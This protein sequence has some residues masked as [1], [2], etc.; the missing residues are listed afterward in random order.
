MSALWCV[1]HFDQSQDGLE[2]SVVDVPVAVQIP[3]ADRRHHFVNN[4]LSALAGI[5]TTT[6][7]WIIF[8]TYESTSYIL[9]MPISKFINENKR[10]KIE[11][12]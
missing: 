4:L 8:V 3:S 6:I 1:S 7:F 12:S 10:D 2:T 9:S 11:L 5:L